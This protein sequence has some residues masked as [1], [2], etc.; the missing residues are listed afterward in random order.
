MPFNF[1]LVNV[2]LVCDHLCIGHQMHKRQLDVY[3][4]L[5]T[6]IAVELQ[7]LTSISV[8]V[9]VAALIRSEIKTPRNIVTCMKYICDE[10]GNL[11]A[12]GSEDLC[13]RI[14]DFRDNR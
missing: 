8:A 7:V 6:C 13:V 3:E 9:A 2:S 1:L 4:S 5:V 14:W 10:S 11:I 12:Q